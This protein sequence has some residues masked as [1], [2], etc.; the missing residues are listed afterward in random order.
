MSNISSRNEFIISR[1]HPCIV[2]VV[3]DGV[4]F[5]N[6]ELLTGKYKMLLTSGYRSFDEQYALWSKG[7]IGPGKVVTNANRG[8]SYHNYG[9]AIDFCLMDSNGKAS[10]NI[11]VDGDGDGVA[12]WY[13]VVYHFRDRLGFIWGGDFHSFKDRCHFEVNYPL[14]RLKDLHKVGRVLSGDYVDIQSDI[15][16][17]CKLLDDNCRDGRHPFVKGWSIVEPELPNVDEVKRDV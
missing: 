13:E 7:R 10:W 14:S 8:D 3:R 17:Y 15:G 5:V 4:D 2:D 11:S 1:L 6:T 9:L 12:D 16:D